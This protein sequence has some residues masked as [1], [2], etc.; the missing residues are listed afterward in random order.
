MTHRGPFQPRPFCDSVIYKFKNI[1]IKVFS[2]CQLPD[3]LY[4]R[5]FHIAILETKNQI[6]IAICAWYFGILTLLHLM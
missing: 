5:Y 3:V 1:F 6:I 2:L 4:V